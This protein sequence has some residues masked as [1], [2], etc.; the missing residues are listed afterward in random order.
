V[1]AEKNFG[2]DMVDATIRNA[3][4]TINVKLIHSSRGKVLRAEPISAM[5]ER[6]KI[7]HRI[8]FLSLEDEMCTYDPEI[9]DS[10]NRMDAAVFAIDELTKL[11]RKKKHVKVDVI[12]IVNRWCNYGKA[13]R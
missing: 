3:H 10:P 2:G 6:K 1:I 8:P 11:S 12:P 9:S 4:P 7:T 13:K 5:Y